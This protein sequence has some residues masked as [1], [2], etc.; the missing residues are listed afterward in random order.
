MTTGQ[1]RE[2]RETP[3]GLHRYI[4][5]TTACTFLLLIAGALVT[6]NDA[7]LSVPD[8]PFA[9]GTLL[10]RMV[11]GVLYEYSHR[12]IAGFVGLLTI[13]LAAWAWK[14]EPRR[15]VRLLAMTALLLVVA[16]AVLGGITV[17]FFLPAPISTAHAAL[18]QLFFCTLVSLALFTSG[19]WQSD[20]P[21]VEEQGRPTLRAVGIATVCV[22]FLQ[23]ILG[24]AFRHNALGVLPHIFGAGVVTAMVVWT[25]TIVF[26]RYGEI[27][28]LRRA[29]KLLVG[30]LGLQ[31]CLGVAA[32]WA[33][34]YQQ[35]L[36]QPYPLPVVLTVAHVVNGA[37]TLATAVWLTL[38]A[39][40]AFGRLGEFAMAAAPQPRRHGQTVSVRTS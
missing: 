8:W 31:L 1:E 3:V 19:W 6:S 30:L 13:G 35:R 22:I 33:V 4:V 15:W 29:A 20:L 38:A 40:R 14:Q 7:G 26:T 12:M 17:L 10:P 9:P 37:L 39:F 27:A 34:L 21:V 25:A 16:Q 5:F 28:P 11:G 36:P 32:Y 18:A 23:L 2:A 24:A